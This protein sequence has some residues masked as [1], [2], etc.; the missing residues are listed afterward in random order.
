M[1]DAALAAFRFDRADK[2]EISFSRASDWFHGRNSLSLS[3]AEPQFGACCDGL[4]PS[5]VNHN[6]GAESTLAYL[7][8]A[9]HNFEMHRLLETM[10]DSDSSVRPFPTGTIVAR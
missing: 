8:I 6:Q 3:L 9:V 4:E 7:W 2:Y 10:A 1:A 5:G